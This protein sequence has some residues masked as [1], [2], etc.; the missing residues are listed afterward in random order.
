MKNNI[1]LEDCWKNIKP[2]K[3]NNSFFGYGCLR[4]TRKKGFKVEKRKYL[5]Y[6]RKYDFDITET[7][8]LDY[9]IIRWLSNHVGGFFKLCGNFDEWDLIDV[10]GNKIDIYDGESINRCNKA[11][12]LRQES[13]QN[14]LKDFL[15]EKQNEKFKD[16]CKFIVP[17]L[18]HFAVY[19]ISYPSQIEEYN[20]IKKWKKAINEFVDKF[21]EKNYDIRFI[22]DL[23]YLW[24]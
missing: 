10:E 6:V 1:E 20:T 14:H 22:R 17:R 8:N 13:F 7:W 21:K 19:T 4:K 23:F 11:Y 2:Y 24:M 3:K 16:F 12:Q 15:D 9:T 18:R 5:R